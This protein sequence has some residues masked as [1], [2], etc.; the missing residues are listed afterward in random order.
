MTSKR[1]MIVDDHVF[2][3]DSLADCFLGN[4]HFKVCGKADGTDAENMVYEQ[5]PDV[6]VMDIIFK[7]INGLDIIKKINE[8][9]KTIKILV[10][11]MGEETIFAESAIRSGA[12]GYIMKSEK[13]EEIL[14]A[15]NKVMEGKLFLSERMT[16]ILLC[17]AMHLNETISK[18]FALAS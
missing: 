9:D 2:L 6:V 14:N 15:L 18:K 1:L 7:G 8:I 11:S 13:I 16:E 17:K 10:L 12:F 5:M 4:E 3:R